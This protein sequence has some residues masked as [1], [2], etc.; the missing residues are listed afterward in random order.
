M[1]YPWTTWVERALDGA[2]WR[3]NRVRTDIAYAV[4]YGYAFIGSSRWE[5]AAGASDYVQVVIPST[6]VMRV[7][8]RIIAVDGGR[9]ELDILE[10]SDITD[11]DTPFRESALNARIGRAPTVQIR[12][13]A[14]SPTIVQ[15]REE[16]LIPSQ[17]GPQSAGAVQD[18]Q[19]FRHLNGDGL[20][21][22]LRVTNTDNA[23][24]TINMTFVWTEEVPSD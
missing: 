3:A 24:H 22:A 12:R 21:L 23:A 13:G 1:T 2:E 19:T 6:T 14:T 18:S 16:S 9:W 7:Y 8:D 10:V 15:V 20:M 5:V 4:E 17:R 11:G